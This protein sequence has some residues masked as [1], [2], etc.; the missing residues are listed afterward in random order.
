[1]TD[2]TPTLNDVFGHEGESAAS[3]L[4]DSDK[5][6]AVAENVSREAGRG[7]P[8]ALAEQ[9]IEKLPLLLDVPLGTILARAWSTSQAYRDFRDRIRG[10]GEEP[11]R[12]PLKEHTVASTHHPAVEV[13]VNEKIVDTL[14]F[15]IKLTLTLRGAVLEARHGRVEALHTGEC[16][17]AGEIRFEGVTLIKR[18]SGPVRLPG[19][20]EL[21]GDAA[22]QGTD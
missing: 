5:L 9:A 3:L 8:G 4:R 17:A 6:A 1:M 15:E 20:I 16:T 10:S 2:A 12:V 22:V 13:L 11:V 14:D 18:A 21:D 19:V 7:D